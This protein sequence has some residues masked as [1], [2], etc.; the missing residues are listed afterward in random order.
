MI[1]INEDFAKLIPPLTEDEYSRLE[2]SILE[3]GCRDA[4][5][6]WGDILIDGHNRY[7]ICTKHNIPYEMRQ[8][9]FENRDNVLLWIMKNQLSRRNLNDFQRIELVRKCEEAVKAQAKERQGTRSDLSTSGQNFPEVKRATDELGKLAGVSRKTYEHATTVLDKA[10]EA[11]VKATRTQELS[12]N[13]AYGV[14]KLPEEQQA[15]IVSRIEQ[16]EA[17]KAVIS[18]LKK[19]KTEAPV[20]VEEATTQTVLTD[21][22]EAKVFFLPL[23]NDEPQNTELSDIEKLRLNIEASKKSIVITELLEGTETRL[24][25]RAEGKKDCILFIW[26]KPEEIPR[27]FYAVFNGEDFKY[28]GVAFVWSQ[29]DIIKEICVIGTRGNAELPNDIEPRVIEAEALEDG[30]H[31]KVFDDMVS[32]MYRR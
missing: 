30:R 8:M 4:L 23:E 26:V 25:I 1:T 9:E 24:R 15:E 16:G 11:I 10:P 31:P 21:E 5:I 6:L 27:L 7:R 17:P 13:A 28:K 32:V 12:I 20:N 18:S 22:Q 2:Q 14:T 19:A 29:E 3:E